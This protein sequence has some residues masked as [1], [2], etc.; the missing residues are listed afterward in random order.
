MEDFCQICLN[1]Q[2][3]YLHRKGGSIT[4]RRM[5]MWGPLFLLKQRNAQFLQKVFHPFFCPI[6]CICQSAPT[7]LSFYVL[8]QTLDK[9]SLTGG[10]GQGVMLKLHCVLM[11]EEVHVCTNRGLSFPGHFKRTSCSTPLMLKDAAGILQKVWQI[12]HGSST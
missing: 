6:V 2:I 7:S 1:C 4:T 12:G 8:L 3:N 5:W 9:I 10:Q 11:W